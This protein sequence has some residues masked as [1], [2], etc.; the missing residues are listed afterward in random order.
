MLFRIDA[1]PNRITTWVMSWFL[2]AAGIALYLHT[3]HNRHLE[4]PEDKV[5]PSL[6]QL[7]QGISDAF[8]KPDAEDQDDSDTASASLVTRFFHSMLWTDTVASAKRF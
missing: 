5:V 1:R 6:R 4:N 2:F 7:G 3:A 8:L